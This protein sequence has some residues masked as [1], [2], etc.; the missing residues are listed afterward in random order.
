[1][2]RENGICRRGCEHR[3]LVQLHLQ[4][5]KHSRPQAGILQAE[6]GRVRYGGLYCIK[7]EARQEIKVKTRKRVLEQ[8]ENYILGRRFE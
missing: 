6:L 2:S 3:Y 7:V 4:H 5:G 8:R 1:M